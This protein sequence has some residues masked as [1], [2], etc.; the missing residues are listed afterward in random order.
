VRKARR[1]VAEADPLDSLASRRIGDLLGN[2][3]GQQRLQF[4]ARAHVVEPAYRNDGAGLWRF[5]DAATPDAE[6]VEMLADTLPGGDAADLPPDPS[7]PPRVEAVPGRPLRPS[8]DLGPVVARHPEWDRAAGIE[9][10]DWVA[11]RDVAAPAGP[12]GR[13]QAML[14]AAPLA[15]QRVSRLLRGVAVG[16]RERLRRQQDGEDLDLAAAVE[17]AIDLRRGVLPDSR[18]HQGVAPRQRDLA[19]CLVL[20]ASESTRAAAG[21][22]GGTVLDGQVHAVALLAEALAG[23]GTPCT[24]QAF[25][26]C[27]RDDVRL[28]RI[29]DPG[30][31]W[32]AAARA[33]LAGVAPGLSTRLGAALRHAGAGLRTQ[34]QHRRLMLVLTDGVPSDIDT[35]AADLL[36]DARRAARS[37]RRDGLDV[38]GVVLG[39][40]GTTA[41]N[42]VFG[43][44]HWVTVPRIERL[45]QRL[46][47]VYA[48]LA[49]H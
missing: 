37:L 16:G 6:T 5:D 38:F 20:D 34:R 3:L 13:V 41:G 8:R 46:S 21:A 43:P 14:D 25:A 44:G 30:A 48:R 7:R 40:D 22:G 49:R 18:I 9:R 11:I 31:S 17:A 26:S 4:D 10:A 23:V 28:S 29:Q 19:V 45:P 2:D 12:P 36:E 39:P 32:D 24:V 47:E 42:G 33:R 35:D 27:G 1:L 15:R